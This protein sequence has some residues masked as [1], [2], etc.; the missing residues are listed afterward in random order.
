MQ[1]LLDRSRQTL[2]DLIGSE[3]ENVVFV[4]NATAGVNAVLRSL[5]LRPGDELLVTNHGYNACNNVVR[6]V[7]ER[8]GGT[9]V[10]AEVPMPVESAEQIVDAVLTRVSDRT[11]LALVDHV[12]SP[13]GIVFPIEELIRRLNERGVDTLV[14]GAHGPGMLPLDMKK[15]GA[16]YYTG[17]CHKWLCAP[18]GAGFLYA[19]PDRQEGLQPP[20]I[21]HGYNQPRP[22]YNRFQDAFDWPG[23]ID[24]TSWLCVGEAIGFMAGLLP[25]GI[26]SIMRRNRALAIAAQRVL[27]ERLPVVPVCPE[28]MLGSLAAVTLPDGVSGLLP[29]PA[30][31]PPLPRLGR[32]LL[33]QFGIEV[34]VYYWQDQTSAILRISAQAFNAIGDYVRLAEVLERLCR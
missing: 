16:A 24:F 7:A 11:R 27:C 33:E 21:S 15:L 22:G 34:P 25:G 23:T 29:E 9:V 32:T 6:Y 13:T 17:N 26:E 14:D 10:V 8:E 31:S 20:V 3:A 12:T 19:R 5:R 18:K 2:A 4:S 28:E 1:P 30:V